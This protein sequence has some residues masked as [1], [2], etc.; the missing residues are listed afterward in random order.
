MEIPVAVILFVLNVLTGVIMYF[1][2][3]AY[4][5]LKQGLQ[6]LQH[7]QERFT[8][9]YLKKEDFRE[10]KEELWKRFDDLKVEIRTMGHK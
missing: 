2:K 7:R 8:E 9:D 4:D 6:A 5:S 10:F 1:M 3:Q